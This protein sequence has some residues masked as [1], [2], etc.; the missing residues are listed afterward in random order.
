[1]GAPILNAVKKVI[2][3]VKD[4]GKAPVE[5]YHIYTL[6]RELAQYESIQ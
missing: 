5:N 6:Q 4:L 2:K 1:M 3:N